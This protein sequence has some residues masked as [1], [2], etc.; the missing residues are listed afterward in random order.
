MSRLPFSIVF[1][2]GEGGK[3]GLVSLVMHNAPYVV[4]DG[5]KAFFA[6]PVPGYAT[7][8][9]YKMLDGIRGPAEPPLM[10]VP[11]PFSMSILENALDEAA[12]I[13][14]PRLIPDADHYDVHATSAAAKILASVGVGMPG[15]VDPIFYVGK[16]R[17]QPAPSN[18]VVRRT[19][20]AAWMA[21]AEDL[22]D[23]PIEEDEIA[24]FRDAC[25]AY[26]W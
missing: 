21:L 13:R 24:A 12:G 20:E 18:E 14:R 5:D 17:N 22:A 19:I 11:P 7:E 9:I 15:Q 1:V 25:A 2:P 8:M 26:G 23:R 4:P 3:D 16:A 6:S 10:P